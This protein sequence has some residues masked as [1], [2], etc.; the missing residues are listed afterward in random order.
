[1]GFS[2]RE[3]VLSADLD[4]FRHVIYLSSFHLRVVKKLHPRC[5]SVKHR[6][7][8][9]LHLLARS[10]AAC[11]RCN[12]DPVR[13]FRG[14]LKG[15]TAD[16]ARRTPAPNA[17][18][19]RRTPVSSY[20]PFDDGV[21]RRARLSSSAAHS[22]HFYNKFIKTRRAVLA[23]CRRPLV[24]AENARKEFLR[25]QRLFLLFAPPCNASI[26][27]LRTNSAQHI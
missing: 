8:H 27:Q 13:L 14:R 22:A 2:K 11:V 9:G 7:T 18:S 26:D 4:F 25:L 16:S 6:N 23:A 21:H 10:R 15:G 12:G 3:L 19:W 1:M 5:S 20:P 17:S 24:P